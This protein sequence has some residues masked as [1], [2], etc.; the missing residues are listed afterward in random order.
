MCAS[1]LSPSEPSETR[2]PG[3]QA[4]FPDYKEKAA[5]LAKRLSTYNV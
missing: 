3:V 4:Y 2:C 1:Q 5:A